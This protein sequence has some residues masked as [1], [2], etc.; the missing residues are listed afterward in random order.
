MGII[1]WDANVGP[2]LRLVDL[3]HAVWCCADVAERAVPV[4]ERARKI[5]RMYDLYSWADVCLVIDE[6]GDR[7]RG[8]RDD[9]A[10]AGRAPGAAIFEKKVR[11]IERNAEALIQPATRR[12]S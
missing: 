5:R 6:I 11:W 3:G 1:D 12:G 7:F 9:H 4:S 8:A 10:R 2:G